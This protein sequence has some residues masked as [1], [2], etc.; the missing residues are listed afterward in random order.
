MVS[1][2]GILKFICLLFFL[3]ELAGQTPKDSNPL[4]FSAIPPAPEAAALGKFIDNPASAYTG[5]PKIDVPIYD[6]KSYELKLPIS[7][8]YH[9][10]GLKWEEIPSWTGAGW[11]LNAGGIVSR[12][13]RG[14]ND[15]DANFGFFTNLPGGTYDVASFFK[16]DGSV[17]TNTI[18][19]TPPSNFSYVAPTG[20]CVTANDKQYQNVLYASKGLLDLEPDLFFFSLPD[21]QS[22]KF[23][24]SRS[25]QMK[26]IPDQFATITYT[27]TP[28]NGQLFYTWKV[29]GKDGTEYFFTKQETTTSYSTCG[30]F[31]NGPGTETFTTPNVNATSSWKL[32]KIRSANKKDSITFTYV[33]ET[34]TYETTPSV[35][36]YN[37]TSGTIA[38]PGAS[39]CLNQTTIYGWRLSEIKTAAGYRV[40]FI[41]NTSRTDL[42]GGKLLDEVKI[43]FQNTFIK[44]FVLTNS[45]GPLPI[46]NSMQERFDEFTAVNV[47]PSYTFTYYTEGV[48]QPVYDRKSYS[49]DHWGYYNA[50]AVVPGAFLSPATVYNNVYYSGSNRESNLAACRWNTLKTITYP[51][52]GTTTYDYDLNEYSNI[53]TFADFKY[54]PGLELIESIDFD[55]STGTSYQQT[56][57]F[58]LAQNTDVVILYEIPAIPGGGVPASGCYGSLS[59][60]SGSPFTT[61]NFLSGNGQTQSAPVTTFT[62]GNFT[63]YG[64]FTPA[65]FNWQGLDWRTLKFFIK[66][67]RVKT[68][69]ELA[70]NNALKGGGLRVKSIVT[71]G[72]Q[73]LTKNYS[74][75][76]RA[77]GIS[78]GKLASFPFYAYVSTFTD[79]QM[80]AALCVANTSGSILVRA[81]ASSLP[82][83][84]SQGS[85]V[86]YDEVTEYYGDAVTNNG[87]TVY[88]FTN[89]PD[90]IVTAYP[91]VPNQSF[92]YKNG[93]LLKQEDYTNSNRL[94]KR[95]TNEY[96]YTPNN[97]IIQGMK[98]AQTTSSGCT[99][100]ANRTFTYSFYLE[101]SERVL[102]TKT[103]SQEFDVTL[104]SYVDNQADYNY[105]S[106]D[107]V[108]LKAETISNGGSKKRYTNYVYDPV[109][110]TTPIEEY[111]YYAVN[112]APNYEF[113]S[114]VK[115]TI[116]GTLLKPTEIYLLETTPGESTSNNPTIL[117]LYKRRLQFTQ[118][119]TQGNVLSFKKEND[120]VTT[121]LIWGYGKSVV[122]DPIT[123]LSGK[124][125]PI[126]QVE[127]AAANQVA[128]TSF[129]NASNE[130]N[131]TFT[132]VTDPIGESKT[133]TQSHLLSQVVSFSGLIATSKYVV[134]YWAKGGVPDVI[135]AAGLVVNSSGDDPAAGADGW[136]YFEKIVT[137]VTTVSIS[138]TVTI[139]IDELRL[140]PVAARMTT[141][142][143]DL[144]TG[145]TSN[146][147]PNHFTTYYEYNSR[148]QMEY[149]KDFEKNYLKKYEYR[150]SRDN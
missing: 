10:S 150:Y 33:T 75:V 68:L 97:A 45:G 70:Q 135:G 49:V 17:N 67:Y 120:P 103:T 106:F 128:F 1:K 59:K 66:I 101:F 50:A 130:G 111:A 108:S 72:D 34:L 127:N 89:T 20:A 52:G 6:L 93:L 21:G 82:L 84:V 125:M 136:R 26:M 118:F 100:C 28:S 55:L 64:E 24:F 41:A 112:N 141:Y 36:S 35:T 146:T 107:Q 80:N 88:N 115:K 145:T 40:Q 42:G 92:S 69:S 83:G 86:G 113:I 61:M 7:L 99:G 126:A 51:T 38:T 23:L 39:S 56:K 119:D 104:D 46:L 149:I 30:E 138:G 47:K 11:A 18:A 53:P 54:T 5:I 85:H 65:S 143:Y 43:Y 142:T 25:K 134:S 117:G 37:K 116:H 15:E 76:N 44:R 79:G 140:Y 110:K 123:N 60:T 14:M 57:N 129:E 105:N 78:S 3:T 148:R 32:E 62:S 9:A 114:G 95:T 74:Y 22:G 16:A 91:F 73:T 27:N 8:S 139:K 102:L 133:G 94:V 71:T 98:V 31:Y 90:A 81:N 147:D 96:T 144:K 121:S 63:L 13:I 124:L 132:L 2:I 122:G 4:K 29:T 12:T 87:Y 131:W 109:L 19:Q 58:A 77:T 48:G 137:G